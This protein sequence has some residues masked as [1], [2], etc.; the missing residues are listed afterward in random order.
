VSKSDQRV[1]A[2]GA[3]DELNAV[4]GVLISLLPKEVAIPPEEMDRIQSNLFHIGAILATTFDSSTFASL[5]GIAEEEIRF[6]ER[7]IDRM[8]E[9]LV[10]LRA[11]ILPRGHLSGAWAHVA[12]TVCRRAERRLIG[13]FTESS[14]DRS[15]KAFRTPL[16]FMNRLSDYLFVVARY[17]NKVHGTEEKIW[18]Q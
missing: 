6:L 17:C 14:A 12:R 1:E 8:E 7:A 4:L 18:G 5:D 2:C 10:P 16:V 11:F 9:E 13:L 3:V 15:N